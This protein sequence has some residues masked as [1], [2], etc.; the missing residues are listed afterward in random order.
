M[1]LEDDPVMMDILL[2]QEQEHVVGLQSSQHKT[3][4]QSYEKGYKSIDV[5]QLYG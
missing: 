1:E 2:Y 5:E 3:S 4:S